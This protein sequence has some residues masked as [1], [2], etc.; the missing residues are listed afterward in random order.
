MNISNSSC[1]VSSILDLL[2]RLPASGETQAAPCSLSAPIADQAMLI[3]LE[4]LVDT[5][6]DF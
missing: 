5:S 4:Q 6:V 1:L 2:V 3:I